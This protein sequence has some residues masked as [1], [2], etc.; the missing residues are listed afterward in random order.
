MWRFCVLIDQKGKKK[1]NIYELLEP[2]FFLFHPNIRNIFIK[3][4]K[5]NKCKIKK[6]HKKEGAL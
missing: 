4:F 5:S 6:G 1:S 3:N 2:I